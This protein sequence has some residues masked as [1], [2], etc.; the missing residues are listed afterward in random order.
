MPHDASSDPA[1]ASLRGRCDGEIH[2]GSSVS[3]FL[4]LLYFANQ[5]QLRQAMTT[6]S[7]ETQTCC[8]CGSDN[9]CTIIA[10][11]N[12]LGAPDLDLRP[13]TMERETM[14]AW[15]QECSQCHY[16]SVDL[17]MESLNAQEIVE[18]AEYQSA[19][20][21]QE[22]PELARRFELCSLLNA[23]STEIAGTA[24]LRSA[25][26]CDDDS[27]VLQAKDYR[28][29]SAVTLSKMRPFED[30]DEATNIGTVLVDVF[31][32]AGEFAESKKLAVTLLK[33]KSVK[34]N[35]VKLSVLA[36]QQSLCSRDDDKC[37][38]L[39]AAMKDSIR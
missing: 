10:S 16:V 24:L 39:D 8:L 1:D 38:T 9:D 29:R 25:W 37:Y 20:A 19:I 18:S 15:L 23:K 26:V 35:Q 3:S 31:R 34:R 5:I 17:A 22:L 2:V 7:N 14:H 32:R 36:F 28:R 11:T 33:F 30:N 27:N 13:S 4:Q 6:Y 21:R 12:T